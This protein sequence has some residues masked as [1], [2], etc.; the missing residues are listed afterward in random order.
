MGQQQGARAQP[1]R[2]GRRLAPRMPAADHD[3]VVTPE[4]LIHGR[5]MYGAWSDVSRFHVKHRGAS[6]LIVPLFRARRSMLV[7]HL[8]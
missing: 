4:N 6:C 7:H 5:R 8:S 2:G 3:D 1:R